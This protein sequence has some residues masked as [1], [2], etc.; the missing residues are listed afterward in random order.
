MLE[1][2]IGRSESQ[3]VCGFSITLVFKSSFGGLKSK[4]PC[5]L[6]NKNTNFNKNDW[7]RKW[8]IPHTVLER[9]TLCFS[10]YKNPK[11]KL[12]LWWVGARERIKRHFL[13]HLFCPKKIFLTFVFYLD[14][15]CIKYTFRIYILLQIKKHYLIELFACV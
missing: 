5:I 6:L 14:L 15:L 13:Y 1:L 3:T 11:M 9:R 12:E 4:S 7:N 10:S 2:K 8:K